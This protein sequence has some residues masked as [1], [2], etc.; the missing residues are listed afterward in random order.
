MRRT[1]D[2]PRPLVWKMMTVAEHVSNWWGFPGFTTQFCDMIV[3][4]S[5][6]W[7]YVM[8]VPDG[9]ELEMHF[10]VAEVDPPHRLVWQHADHGV[11]QGVPPAASVTTVR[12]SDI[13]A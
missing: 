10:V 12:L 9:R 6:L 8:S 1:F 2:A 13:G 4:P 3:R 5:G 7:H 11:L